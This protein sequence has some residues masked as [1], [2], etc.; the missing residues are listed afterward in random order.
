MAWKCV[1]GGTDRTSW[2]SQD[3]G[4]SI[5]KPL[6]ERAT[7]TLTLLPGYT[8]A[9]QSSVVIYAQDGTT[10]IFGGLVYDR[11]TVGAHQLTFV[12][13]EVVDYSVY[14][15]WRYVDVDYVSAYEGEPAPDVALKT[16]LTEIVSDLSGFGV[17]LDAGQVDGPDLAAFVAD[18]V[19]ASDLLRE[20]QQK[21]GY[22]ITWSPTKVLAMVPP[23]LTSGPEPI[24]D[25]SANALSLEWRESLENYATRVHLYCGPDG[26][27]ET[28]Q[29]WQG[30]GS[31]DSWTTD[32][33]ATA[34]DPT[35][36]LETTTIGG[37]SSTAVRT[38]TTRTVYSVTSSS[39]ANPTVITTSKAH[40]FS[41][42]DTVKI[43]GHSGSTPSING[44][45]TIL[46]VP[47]DTSFTI[48]VNVTD[49]G[50][51]G[52]VVE[53]RADYR[54]V[55]SSHTLYVDQ[56][57]VPGADT[58]VRLDFTGLF[59]FRVMADAGV[60]PAIIFRA[61]APDITQK[62]VG[63]EVVDGLLAQKYQRPYEVECE[64]LVVGWEPG[65]QVAASSTYRGGLDVL[66]L[67]TE[68]QIELTTDALWLYRFRGIGLDST[69]PALYQGS[70]LDYYRAIATG[71]ST[72]Q[73]SGAGGGSTTIVNLSSPFPLGG[74]R[75]S[76]LTVAA[77]PAWTP[78]IDWST[79]RAASS[80]SVRVRVSLWARSVG[81][82]VT[83]R[84]YDISTATAAATSSKVTA[85]TATETTFTAALT[86][87]HQYRLEVLSD[88]ASE[89]VYAIG[90]LE[91]L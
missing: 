68:V 10:P 49:G 39:V 89:S 37:V 90:V 57:S 84:L 2:L 24:T 16:V 50:S 77:S 20:L 23:G 76:S 54:W 56:A 61:S 87:G 27:G 13:L 9:L 81:V 48:N 85:T 21:T 5:T 4:V 80:F 29:I 19:R 55:R 47:S 30:D 31:T 66:V 91:N 52:T 79:Y 32:I 41:A 60:S 34:P 73:I 58:T 7:A 11:R 33:R 15:D 74:A 69:T 6:N 3:A 75:L 42:G 71:G 65:Q 70:P 22:H 59:P 63:Q 18:G 53:S 62:D 40:N 38:V 44:T 35:Y 43:S 67:I 83:A 86:A 64:T 46:A 36:V 28:Y 45:H 17:T 78:V 14:A 12:E 82:G 51:G 25:A 26:A 8:A 88:T 72:A 1:I